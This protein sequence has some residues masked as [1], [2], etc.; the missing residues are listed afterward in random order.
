MEKSKLLISIFFMCLLVSCNKNESPT[1]SNSELSFNES[2]PSEQNP[3]NEYEEQLKHLTESFIISN[4]NDSFN[5]NEN[6]KYYKFVA[7]HDDTYALV[8]DNYL[9]LTLVDKKYQLIKE[10]Y[11]EVSIFLKTNEEVYLIAEQMDENDNEI[12]IE[13]YYLNNQIKLPYQTNFKDETI[14]VSY[15]DETNI[16]KEANISYKGRDGGTYVYSNNPELF[17]DNDLNTCLMKNENLNGEVYMAFEHA[18]YS[19]NDRVYLG[20]KLVNQEDHD[21]YITVENIGYQAG[22]SWFGQ[23]AWYDFYNTKFTLPS[24][25]LVNGVISSKYAGYDYAYKDYTPRI[26]TPTTYKLPA[27]ESFFVIGG[28]SNSSYNNINVDNTANKPLGKIKCANGQVKFD[29]TQGK[30]TGMMLI[31]TDDKMISNDMDEVGYVTLRDGKN[32]AAQ[33]Q[34]IANHKGVIDSHIK[35]EFNDNISSRALPVTFTNKLATSTSFKNPYEAY[36]LIEK[37]HFGTSW[38]THLNPQNGNNAV[39]SDIVE[40]ICKTTDKKQVVIDNYHADGAGET[41]NTANWMIENQDHFTF[42]NRGNKVRKIKMKLK[43]HGT[44]ATLLREKDGTVIENYYSVGLADQS[45][46][47]YIIEV[48][49]QSY[50]Q[51]VLDYLLVACSYGSVTHEVE[52]N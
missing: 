14:D 21:V 44:L 12:Y 13:T 35:W 23:L 11:N 43:D 52:L 39:G 50:K 41:A 16:L 28:T 32:Y 40:F 22:G 29:V 18:N 4:I 7:D 37:E 8:S 31:Y 2:T 48:L 36:D 3:I 47:E 20:Y 9:K 24:D 49:P 10:E 15:S 26:Y 34:G 25:Y 46:N 30:V 45:F 27:H 33:Y 19:S 5:E 17:A 1:S 42:V 51:V 38:V 6:K